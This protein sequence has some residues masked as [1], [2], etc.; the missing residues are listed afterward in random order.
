[1]QAVFRG[2]RARISAG[3][4]VATKA[5]S[6]VGADERSRPVNCRNTSSRVA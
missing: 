1:M 5:W 6:R 3:A 2:A 4:H